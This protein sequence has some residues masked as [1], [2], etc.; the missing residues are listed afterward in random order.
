[1]PGGTSKVTEKGQV[2]IPRDIRER[3]KMEPGST[4]VFVEVD[5]KVVLSRFEDIE[6]LFRRSHQETRNLGITRADVNKAVKAARK[7]SSA[8]YAAKYGLARRT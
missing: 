2:T 3:F 8:K 5:G 4:V 7:E 1:M 6:E